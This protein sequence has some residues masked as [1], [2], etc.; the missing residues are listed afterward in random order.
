MRKEG[1]ASIQSLRA[2]TEAKVVRIHDRQDEMQSSMVSRAD[3]EALRTDV[4]GLG[5]Q[6]AELTATVV[7]LFTA[8]RAAE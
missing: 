3:L 8:F 7:K 4:R 2:E 1:E 5:S 6:I